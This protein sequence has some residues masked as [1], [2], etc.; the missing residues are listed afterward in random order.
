M[1]GLGVRVISR[2]VVPLASRLAWGVG[3]EERDN[4]REREVT[5]CDPLSAVLYPA[6]PSPSDMAPADA[7]NTTRGNMM[8]IVTGPAGC[9]CRS[10]LQD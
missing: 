1:I 5:L 6:V 2:T 7:A 8:I 9:G 4:D 10:S 3:V